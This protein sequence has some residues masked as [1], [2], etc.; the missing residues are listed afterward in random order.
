M[1]LKPKHIQQLRVLSYITIGLLGI[2]LIISAVER[3]GENR[4]KDVLVDVEPLPDGSILIKKE[5]VFLAIDRSFGYPLNSVPLIEV[6]M[7]RLERILEEDPFVLDAET[8]ID[9]KNQLAIQIVQREPVIRVIDNNGLNYFLDNTGVK[10]KTSPH[11]S[12][13]VLVFTGNIPPYSTDFITSEKPHLLRELFYLGKMIR[14]DE[15]F[16]PMIEQ[17]HVGNQ[18]EVTLVPK[19]GGQK[20][21]FGRLRME[22]DKLRR[23]K[24][25]YEEATPYEGWRKYRSLDLRYEGQVVAKR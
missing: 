3:K 4:V 16:E 6:D 15:F 20:I 22:E 14:A 7:E 25:F 19:I 17:I 5:D 2:L 18:N 24:I 10:M 21:F 8:Y 23:L 12:P 11:A 9:A 13:H 1:K